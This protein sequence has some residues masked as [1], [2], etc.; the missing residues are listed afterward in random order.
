MIYFSLSIIKFK[1]LSI[2]IVAIIV[3]ESLVTFHGQK[4]RTG[5]DWPKG[6]SR[7]RVLSIVIIATIVRDGDSYVCVS[8]NIVYG[9]FNSDGNHKRL[10]QNISNTGLKVDMHFAARIGSKFTVPTSQDLNHLWSSCRNFNEVKYALH[11]YKDDK[12]R[13]LFDKPIVWPVTH[14]VLKMNQKL[15]GPGKK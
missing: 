9:Y 7:V 2:V 12:S 15:T 10:A 5:W 3:I 11:L 1:G 14:L 8:S 6:V 4:D 13:V